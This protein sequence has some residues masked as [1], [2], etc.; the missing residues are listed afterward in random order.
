MGGQSFPL[1]LAKEG[2]RNV[3]G[4]WSN[5]IREIR[6]TNRVGRYRPEEI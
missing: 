6:F 1:A 4:R 2:S 5:K 3:K